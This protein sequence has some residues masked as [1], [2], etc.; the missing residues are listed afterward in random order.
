MYSNIAI[1]LDTLSVGGTERA[2]VNLANI[3]AERSFNVH[4]IVTTTV[5]GGGQ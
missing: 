5:G 4:V 2:V 3:F 1:L